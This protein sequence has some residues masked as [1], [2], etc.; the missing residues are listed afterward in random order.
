MVYFCAMIHDD[1]NMIHV[2]DASK[3]TNFQIMTHEYDSSASGREIT[4]APSS[5]L[6]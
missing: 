2:E 5:D 4:A 6:P 1:M 3:V